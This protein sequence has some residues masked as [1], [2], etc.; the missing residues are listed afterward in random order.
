HHIANLQW[1]A[2]SIWHVSGEFATGGNRIDNN[3]ITAPQVGELPGHHCCWTTDECGIV[4]PDHNHRLEHAICQACLQE[5]FVQRY[6]PLHAVDTAYTEQLRLLEWLDVINELYL[7]V[8]DPDVRQP[9]IGNKTIRARHDAYKDAQL[10]FD[11]E[12]G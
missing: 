11:E 2:G 6:G 9:G 5:S 10:L 4:E 12:R 7:G 1:H 3:A 8:H